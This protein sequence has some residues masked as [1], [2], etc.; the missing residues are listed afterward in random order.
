MNPKEKESGLARFM[1]GCWRSLSWLLGRLSKL[2]DKI[3]Y[4]K[5][6]SLVVS[7]LIA[8]GLCV[9]ANYE[10]I[11]Y[12]FFSHN[13]SQLNI[14]AVPVEVRYDEQKYEVTGLPSTADLTV[15]GN[16]A[17]I[18]VFRT[19]NN[20][21]IIADLRSLSS[22]TNEVELT[23]GNIPSQLRY[24][25]RPANV[26]VDIEEKKSKAFA[27]EPEL[28]LGTGQTAGEFQTP[29][30]SVKNVTIRAASSK[31]DSIRSVKAIVDASGQTGDFTISA[32]LVAYDSAGNRVSVDFSV[33]SV[34]AE[35][36]LR[37]KDEDAKE[38]GGT[39]NKDGA[40]DT[41]KDSG[42]A[43]DAAK[44]EAAQNAAG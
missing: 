29:V 26:K 39:A 28:L 3:V 44:S 18:Q 30:L 43:E 24:E 25:I 6:A 4:S 35:V 42:K 2:F 10:D 8:I 1:K 14:S 12:Q 31:L 33:D 11:Y 20:A 22:G 19:Q 5:K 38:N 37:P 7:L 13:E 23:A 27:I 34:S 36:K 15:T 32:P 40:K 41:D 16:P 21:V 9:S 17:D